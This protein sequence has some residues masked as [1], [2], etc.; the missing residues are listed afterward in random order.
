MSEIESVNSALP[1]HGVSDCKVGFIFIL[2]FLFY[3]SFSVGFF[4]VADRQRFGDDPEPD[5]D[6]AISLNA[7]PDPSVKVG[8]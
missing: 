7:D 8:N 5:Q 3:C 2:L 1:K 4:R 6:P